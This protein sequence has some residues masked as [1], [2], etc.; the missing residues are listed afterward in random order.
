MDRQME[1]QKNKIR[2]KAPERY[3]VQRFDMSPALALRSKTHP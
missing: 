3:V 2:E 1:N